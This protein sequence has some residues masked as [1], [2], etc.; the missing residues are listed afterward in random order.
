[1]RE[2]LIARD[3][4]AIISW[5]PLAWCILCYAI[6]RICKNSQPSSYCLLLSLF[7]LSFS[8]PSEAG[9]TCCKCRLSW[10]LKK[11]NRTGSTSDCSRERLIC[12][13]LYRRQKILFGNFKW[14]LYARH[15]HCH[16]IIDTEEYFRTCNQSLISEREREREFSATSRYY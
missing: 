6:S 5:V 14:L 9:V 10:R 1:M 3:A 12:C 13:V 4:S 8:L 2:E 11:V 16:V 7:L 15:H